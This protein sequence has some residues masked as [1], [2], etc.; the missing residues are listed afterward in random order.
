MYESMNGQSIYLNNFFPPAGSFAG[1]M[2]PAVQTQ[3]K[4]LIRI[5]GKSNA[6]NP[7]L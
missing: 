7:A 3:Q 2:Y 1:L 4:K 6:L 5:L